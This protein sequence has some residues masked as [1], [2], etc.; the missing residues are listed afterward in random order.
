MNIVFLG[1]TIIILTAGVT[2]VILS[3]KSEIRK[4][5]N[6]DDIKESTP[7]QARLS[8]GDGFRFGIGFALGTLFVS[9]VLFTLI[10]ALTVE[11]LQNLLSLL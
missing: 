7:K 6:H 5:K 4:I 2:W 3:A 9:L 11:L 8:I 1:L 10:S